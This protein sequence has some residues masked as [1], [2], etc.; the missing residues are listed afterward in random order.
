MAKTQWLFEPTDRH[1]KV[2]FNGQI[3]ADSKRA[4][5]LKESRYELHY[6]FPE[7]DV[8]MDLLEKSDHTESSG[9]KGESTF[10]HV[11]AG[12]RTADN[13]A[14]TFP[15]EKDNRPDLRGYIAFKWHEMDHWYE[16]A[17]E[18][19][20][21]PRDPYHRVDTIPSNRHIRVEVD[22]VT[23]AESARPV[24]LFETGL[25]TRYYIPPEDVDVQYLKSSSTHTRCPYKG[26]ASYWSLQ[27]DGD[28]KKDLVWGY[29]DPIPEIPRIKGL[30]AFYNEKLDIYVDGALEEKPRTVFG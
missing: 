27:V 23:I 20:G 12:D 9:Y 21:H 13:A 25:P 7:A 29:L 3:V 28:E 10:W 6:Y 30:M 15:N 17:E 14:W 26:L 5:L 4:M 24:L 22:G 18:V 16:E 8:R 19:F 11:Q 1:I 2:Q